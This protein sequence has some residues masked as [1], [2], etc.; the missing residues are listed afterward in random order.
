MQKRI[1]NQ[2]KI[3]AKS[4]QEKGMQNLLQTRSVTAAPLGHQPMKANRSEARNRQI[5]AILA[6]KGCPKIKKIQP[7]N[8]P[9][10]FQAPVYFRKSRFWPKMVTK[11][12]QK[13]E[14]GACFWRPK[15]DPKRSKNA[16]ATQPRFFI[17][18]GSI[19]GAILMIF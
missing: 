19:L 9:G 8:A 5:L 16:S 3:Y 4:M 12:H 13:A 15:A 10:C 17:D 11:K 1:K 7:L 2:S 14:D 6:K 18:L